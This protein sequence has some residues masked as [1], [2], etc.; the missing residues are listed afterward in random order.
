M[1]FI[2]SKLM[3]PLVAPETWIVIGL[4]IASLAN[5][6][7]RHR[8]A[9]IAAI[10]TLTFTVTIALFPMG[11]L[12]ISRLEISFPA[13]PTLNRI[14]GIIVLGGG[15][16]ASTTAFWGQPQ[17]NEAGERLTVALTLARRFPQARILFTGG[18]GELHPP[19]SDETESTVAEQFFSEQGISQ[20]RL[21]LE[22]KSRNTSENARM[23]FELLCPRDGDVWVLVTSAFHMP[24]AMLSFRRAGW[25]NVIPFPVDSAQAPLRTELAGNSQPIS[26]C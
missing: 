4:L 1:F 8:W 16:D 25:P 18:R 3:W 5:L 20:D 13:K 22:R 12:L 11:E 2:A 17:L 19:Y 14:E 26:I 24:R 6:R 7:G 15:E 21:I 23:S 10:L 9:K